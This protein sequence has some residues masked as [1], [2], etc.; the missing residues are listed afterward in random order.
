M[1]IS[2]FYETKQT[3]EGLVSFA[4]NDQQGNRYFGKLNGKLMFSKSHN[5]RDA[6]KIFSLFNQCY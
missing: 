5:Q 4:K 1:V 6:V 2:A 3:A